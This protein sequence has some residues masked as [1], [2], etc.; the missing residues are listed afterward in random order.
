MGFLNKFRIPT[1]LGLFIIVT[2]LA[3]GVYLVLQNQT[4]QTKAGADVTAKNITV[5][6]I[7]DSGF[8]VSWQTD[9]KSSG[10]LYLE[11]GGK[12]ETF[13][14]DQDLSTPEPRLL[15]HVS[16][17]SLAPQTTYFYTIH[18]SK[19]KMPPSQVTT[20]ALDLPNSYQPI[21]GQVLS[22]SAF[23]S[24]GL[25]FLEIPGVITQSTTIKDY[26]NF[27]LPVSSM[28]KADLSGVFIPDNQTV[29]KI[30]IMDKSSSQTVVTF[31]LPDRLP[32]IQMGTNLNLAQ[33]VATSSAN[34]SRFDL[35]GDGRVNSS[36][37]A[38]VLKN[39]VDLN[40]DGVVNQKDLKLM[41][42][43]INQ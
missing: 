25:V 39:Q 35:N 37:Y 23:L 41:Q 36:D 19:L 9:G 18:S 15:H 20:G 38:M 14:D 31:Y 40:E 13:L 30:T 28:Q 5:T 33:K 42:E 22:D 24:S 27:I 11:G 26:G 34:L 3:S 6:N 8:A 21:I 17:S 43:Q 16:V 2:G 32:P 10:F 1:L 12:S 7:S 4:L 29:G